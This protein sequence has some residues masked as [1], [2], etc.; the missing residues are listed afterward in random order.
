MHDALGLYEALVARGSSPALTWYC[1]Q[2]RMELSGAV[3]A[4][5]LA[6]ISSF[7]T[8][9]AWGQ[10]SETA[11]LY[12]PCHWKSVLWALGAMIAGLQVELVDSLDGANESEEAAVL[13]THRP[14]EATGARE[15]VAVDMNPL[16]FGWS[17][18]PLPD[19][20]LDGSAG[21]ISQP[22]V[23]MDTESHTASNFGT[24]VAAGSLPD[25]ERLLIKEKELARV[26]TAAAIQLGRGSIVVADRK[27]AERAEAERATLAQLES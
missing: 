14:H 25:G 7:L 23:L 24:W 3:V 9:E 22:D 2:G 16:A 21:Q 26:L 5:H 27:A 8:E 1:P 12:L 19:G 13:I 17:G 18:P 6:K 4:N 11:R 15:V 10:P 20:V